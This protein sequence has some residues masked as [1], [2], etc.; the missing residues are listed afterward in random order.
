M[1]V[2]P[3]TD[4]VLPRDDVVNVRCD[5]RVVWLGL[6]DRFVV[7]GTRSSDKAGDLAVAPPLSLCGQGGGR[8]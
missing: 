6:V 4:A 3:T 8:L 5:R 7:P 2:A 1:T